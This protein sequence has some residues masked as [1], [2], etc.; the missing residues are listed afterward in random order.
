LNVPSKNQQ[1][2]NLQNSIL[3]SLFSYKHEEIIHIFTLLTYNESMRGDV[4]TI[5]TD[6]LPKGAGKKL[7]NQF[8]PT[9]IIRKLQPLSLLNSPYAVFASHFRPSWAR[10]EMTSKNCV[11]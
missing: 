5:G 7:N 9:V 3:I 8:D 11:R 1:D 10:S 2:I 4:N 6:H